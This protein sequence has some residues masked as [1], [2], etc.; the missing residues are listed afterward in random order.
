MRKPTTLATAALIAATLLPG[1]GALP[2]GAQAPC[3]PADPSP[4]PSPGELVLMPE[5]ARIRL[6]DEVWQSVDLGY[7]DAGYNGVDWAAIGDE[8][9]PYFLQVES[10]QEVYDLAAEMV[11]LLGDDEAA[12]T[13]A[14]TVEAFVPEPDDYVGIGALVDENA[15]ETE[16]AG[17]RILYLFAGSGALDAGIRPRDRILS[18]DG[19]PCVAVGKIRGPEGTT[20]E[21]EVVAPGEE[22]RTVVVERRRIDPAILPVVR[23]LG[24]DDGIG[25][26]RL[27]SLEGPELLA[28]ADEALGGFAEAGVRGIVLDVRSTNV[29]APGVTVALLSHLMTGDAGALYTRIESAPIELPESDLVDAL[30]DVPLAILV[31]ELTIGEAERLALILQAAGRATLVGEPT[32]GRTRSVR[33]LPLDD[34]SVLTL[35][36]IGLELPGG[37]RLMREGAVPDVDVTEDWLDFPEADDPGILAAIAAIEDAAANGVVARAP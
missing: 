12:F 10:A 20:V 37:R 35:P 8:F 7:L 36:T 33:D 11:E 2:V 15:A 5:D 4:A 32:E 28:A 24:T 25:Y 29:G 34:G 17:P 16:G 13:D 27:D 19:D 26:L 22:P 21:L 6:F 9:A 23:T 1:A 30:G 31:D 14:F 18:V 3:P